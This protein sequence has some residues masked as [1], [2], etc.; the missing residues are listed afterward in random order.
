MG[1][2]TTWPSWPG[3]G[4]ATNG[5]AG[6]AGAG[7]ASAG[8]GAVPEPGV[9]ADAGAMLT[10]PP[11]TI[12]T[13]SS[14]SVISSSAMPDSCTRSISFF[15][16]RRSIASLPS[17][18]RLIPRTCGPFSGVFCRLYGF[19]AGERRILAQQ[20]SEDP[21]QFRSGERA[22]PAMSN[23]PPL[24]EH[25]SIG[26]SAKAVSQAAHQLDR[27]SLSYKYGVR[28]AVGLGKFIDF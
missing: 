27:A 15:S 7:R 17:G 28:D 14:P 23:Y 20:A 22:E 16:L 13:F 18:W 2:F 25:D 19:F 4:S 21:L 11:L 10:A 12:F 1:A 26:Q 9:A 8:A 6:A 24:I 5:A 3:S